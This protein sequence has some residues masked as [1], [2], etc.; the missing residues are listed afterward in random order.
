MEARHL[1]F[2]CEKMEH[3]TS[4]RVYLIANLLQNLSAECRRGI[5]T[6]QIAREARTIEESRSILSRYLKSIDKEL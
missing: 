1:S 6:M 5:E 2:A 4:H 3:L